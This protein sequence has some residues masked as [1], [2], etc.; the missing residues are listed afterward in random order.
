MKKKISTYAKENDL[1]YLTVWNMLQRKELPFIRT[2]KGTYLIL[3]DNIEEKVLGNRVVLYAR[4]SSSENKSN[5]VSQLERL[6]NYAIAKG[7]TI[8]K[9][10]KEVGSGLNDK[11]QQLLKVLQTDDWNIIIVEHKDRFARFGINYIELLLNKLNKKLEIINTTED[12][13]KEDLLVDFVSIITSFT[14]R[15]YGLRRSKRKTEEIIK[16]LNLEAM[17]EKQSD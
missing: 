4:V 11:R 3:E 2:P 13:T 1:T 9:E 6:R 15:L 10:V 5:L 17:D 14:A 16:Q 8:V 12:N 7:Y